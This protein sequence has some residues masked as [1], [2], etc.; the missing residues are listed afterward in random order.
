[1]SATTTNTKP[2][3]ALKRVAFFPGCLIP[4]RYPH[5]EA[6]LRRTLPNL[7]IE[8]VDV[9]GFTC[10]P[11]PIHFKA[12]DK[13]SWLT[14]ATRNL[15]LAEE[16]GLEIFTCC[17]GC[18]ATLSE[19]S[20]LLA[21]D[22]ELRGRINERLKRIGKHYKGT[23]RVRHVVTLIRDEIG[24]EKVKSSVKRPLEGLRIAIHYGC[25]L[26]K[27]SPIMNVDDPDNPV[28]MENLVKAIGAIPVRHEEWILCCGKS[29]GDG[30]IRQE[31]METLLSSIKD[32]EPD[33]LCLICPSCFGE[34]DV[35]Q[36][37]ATRR[38]NRDVKTPAAYF[39]QLLGLAQ[40][41]SAEAVGLD[42]HRVKPEKVL[43]YYGSALAEV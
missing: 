14:M 36:I 33:C 35:G 18:T 1:M 28:M 27:P 25:H 19:A 3:S 16:Q 22:E 38:L 29:V 42:R 41:F 17:S 11:D 8:I 2:G 30:K 10:C 32:K 12:A 15:C 24:L 31:M 6:A 5:M 9:D 43:E 13:L 40:G 4:I 34:F 39:F 20:D 7:G 23:T 21:H 37:H 26:L